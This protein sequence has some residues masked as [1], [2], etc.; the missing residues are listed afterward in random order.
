MDGGFRQS[1][2]IDMAVKIKNNTAT[3]FDVQFMSRYGYSI[4][5]AKILADMPW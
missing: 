3:N 1:E 5:D 2:L 4:D